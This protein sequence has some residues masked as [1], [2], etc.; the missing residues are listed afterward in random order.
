[1]AEQGWRWPGWWTNARDAC[2][3][4]IHAGQN[5]SESDQWTV[6]RKVL[7]WKD[8]QWG[9]WNNSLNWRKVFKCLYFIWQIRYLE[10]NLFTWC[11][12]PWVFWLPWKP[13][14]YF[15]T[16]ITAKI[17][18]FSFMLWG[19]IVQDEICNNFPTV[20][21]VRISLVWPLLGAVT[22]SYAP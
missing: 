11:L 21:S 13:K 1:M 14:L 5:W 19:N 4:G 17:S 22:H 2:V 3:K 10:H 15:L 18:I 20:Y 9:S 12:C 16:L 8:I 6:G 7:C